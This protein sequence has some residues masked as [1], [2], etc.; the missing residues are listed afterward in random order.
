MSSTM[1]DAVRA[2]L[3]TQSALGSLLLTIPSSMLGQ[4]PS[5]AGQLVFSLVLTNKF[6]YSSSGSVSVSKSGSSQL[7]L[8]LSGPAYQLGSRSQPFQVQASTDM[9]STARLCGQAISSLSVTFAWTQASASTV[10]GLSS[11]TIGGVSLSGLTL[12]GSILSGTVSQ[13]SLTL[14][15][16]SMTAGSTY[17]VCW[18]MVFS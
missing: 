14:P 4:T 1:I 18:M 17:G 7:P 13:S 2:V 6:N 5:G 11:M 8:T 16:Y 12:G 10:P 3:Q 15:A 9:T